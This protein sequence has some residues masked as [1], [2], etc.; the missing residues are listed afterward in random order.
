MSPLTALSRNACFLEGQSYGNA[1]SIAKRLKELDFTI[2]TVLLGQIYRFVSIP[3]IELS[4]VDI[5]YS[6]SVET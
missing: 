6:L 1:G 3:A 2:T 5:G 4:F